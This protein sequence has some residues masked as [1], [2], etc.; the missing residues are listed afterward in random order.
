MFRTHLQKDDAGSFDA[1]RG[2]RILTAIYYVSSLAGCK[3]PADIFLT[4]MFVHELPPA[5]L[6]KYFLI[7]KYVT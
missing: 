2:N 4:F 3:V 6:Q 7:L 1:W 5:S